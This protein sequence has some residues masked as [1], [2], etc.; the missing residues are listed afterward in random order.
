MTSCA[1]LITLAHVTRMMG[2]EKHSEAA[3]PEISEQLV[4]GGRW[5]MRKERVV[6]EDG[7]FL[8]FYTFEDVEAAEG[9]EF[10]PRMERNTDG[11]IP[12]RSHAE[13]VHHGG[14][15]GAEKFVQKSCRC[16]G[17]N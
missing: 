12:H 14:T 1:S 10:D 11:E 6:K 15:E 16:Q 9:N 2:K 7:R 13:E 4:A 3:T 5:L 17:S 8:I